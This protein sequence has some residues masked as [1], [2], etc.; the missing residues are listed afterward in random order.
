MPRRRYIYEAGGLAFHFFFEKGFESVLHITAEHSTLPSDA[1]E[2]FRSGS[3][4][5]DEVHNRFVTRTLTHELLW[6]WIE[7]DQSLYV[8]TFRGR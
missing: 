3:T 6:N 1:P 8:I 7:Q 2:V 4:E 5:F